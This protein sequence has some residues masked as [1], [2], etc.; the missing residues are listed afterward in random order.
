MSAAAYHPGQKNT[1]VFAVGK[2]RESAT[3]SVG[4]HEAMHALFD[5]HG[6]VDEATRKIVNLEL[7]GLFRLYGRQNRIFGSAYLDEE[8]TEFVAECG[9]LYHLDPEWL[10][11]QAPEVY[12]WMRRWFND[13]ARHYPRTFQ[14][15][16]LLSSA[17]ESC[18]SACQDTSLT[19]TAMARSC[20]MG[21]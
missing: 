14:A 9:T 16:A 19:D 6:V 8:P 15:E 2:Q 18:S 11:A 12:T 17:M 21:E 4:V 1:I 13:L 7:A 20:P 3:M 5:Q 10:K